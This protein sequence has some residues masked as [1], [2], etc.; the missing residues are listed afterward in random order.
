MFRFLFLTS[1]FTFWILTSAQIQD[2][3]CPWNEVN[4]PGKCGR[5]FDMNGDGYCD[6]GRV[7]MPQ[8]T[9]SQSVQK[10]SPST[11]IPNMRQPKSNANH[12]KST[13]DKTIFSFKFNK[14]FLQPSCIA[15][16][17]TQKR[18]YNFFLI[19]GII[20]GMYL[21]SSWLTAKGKIKKQ[22]HFKFWNLMLL[23]T[24]LVSGILGFLL[25]FQIN[26]NWQIGWIKDFLYYH[27]QFGIAMGWISIF[28]I[29]WHRKYFIGYFKKSS[30]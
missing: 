13:F 21:F 3:V 22:Q 20:T 30:G 25:V 14:I 26:Y 15:I 16:M 18:H 10:S 23:L 1:F 2:F 28:H 27:V 24:F 19:A 17:P 4:C 7:E 9:T 12:S 6:Y 11:T 8:D 29:W 5:F